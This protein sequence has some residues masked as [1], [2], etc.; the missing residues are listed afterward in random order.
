M[1][2]NIY[3]KT[4]NIKSV[5]FYITLVLAG[6]IGNYFNV[7]LFYG[8]NF[9]FGGIF[10]FIIVLL[11]GT[12]WGTAAALII[13]SYTYFLWNHPYGM[14][15]FTL[16]A[17]FVGLLYKNKKINLV[18]VDFCFWVVAG[19]PLIWFSYKYM[20]DF[21]AGQTIL[22]LLKDIINGIFNSLTASILMFYVPFEQW[23]HKKWT[24]KKR[25]RKPVPMQRYIFSLIISGIIIPTLIIVFSNSY[26]EFNNTMENIKKHTSHY[27]TEISN[28]VKEYNERYLNALTFLSDKI[29]DHETSMVK[30]E[31]ENVLKIFPD[32]LAMY[33]AD[34]KG[35]VIAIDYQNENIENT[36]SELNFSDRDYFK[37]VKSEMKPVISDVFQGRGGLFQPIVIISVPVV[38]DENFEGIICAAV[39]IEHVLNTKVNSDNPEN[40]H[41]SITD[42]SNC[43]VASTIPGLE[44]MYDYDKRKGFVRE[45]KLNGGYIW[46]GT[47]KSN[48][49]VQ[50]WENSSYIYK[51]PVGGK[52][53]WSVIVEKPFAVYQHQLQT[54]YIRN[55]LIIIGVILISFL[56]AFYHSNSFTVP[57]KKLVDISSYLP[58]RLKSLNKIVWPTSWIQE[59]DNLVQNYRKAA[60]KLEDNFKE[61]TEANKLLKK[62]TKHDP[63][64]SLPNMN[65]LRN[66]FSS[67]MI[68]AD[69]RKFKMG[70]LFLD[71]DYFQRVNDILGRPQGDQLLK[72][73]AKRVGNSVKGKGQLYHIGG[74]EFV[75][76]IYN[77][78]DSGD[79]KKIAETIIK[80]LKIPFYFKSQEFYITISIGTAVFPE[81]GETLSILMTN[82]SKAMYAAKDKGKNTVEE[83]TPVMDT[84]ILRTLNLQKDLDKALEREEFLLEY[85]PQVEVRTGQIIGVE[86]L[87][88]WNNPKVGLISPNEFIPLAEETGHIIPIGEW[89]IREACRQNKMWMEK[90]YR[91]VKVAVNLCVCQFQHDDIVEKVENILNQVGLES[92]YLELEITE[93]I[94]INDVYYAIKV[95][96]RLKEMGVNIALDDFGTGFSS[97]NYIRN[98]NI[99]KLKIDQ[100]FI[101]DIYINGKLNKSNAVIIK[102]IID[103]AKN[104]N[105][106]VISEGVETQRQFRFVQKHGCDEVQGFYLSKPLPAGEIE[107]VLEEGG[108]MKIAR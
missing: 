52:V 10:I 12:F 49:V 4:F 103:L 63:L 26:K 96:N 43:I 83:C 40:T 88:R 23:L 100:S 90:G 67:K 92:K 42:S 7:T 60:G 94:I 68:Q 50:Q 108:F 35:S 44:M 93:S 54:Q 76:I 32:I 77:L 24:C 91:P 19:F 85:Q 78:N 99:D 80:E 2:K 38:G 36:H 18:V 15:V 33:V 30:S 62:M 66:D 74:D 1:L 22:V 58:Y 65:S 34:S 73:F 86:A 29:A 87:L 57:L 61:I 3:S 81:D 48:T 16:E 97:L 45:Y 28:Y 5:L 6:I 47:D 98:F 31:I 56:F 64:T 84:A 11:Y 104:L 37:D 39:D 27:A 79:C 25:E 53:P 20:M 21:S 14:I 106:K 59:I 41:I 72:L 107:R 17:L 46:T 105:L 69:N 51:M 75:V 101:K 9:L 82:A 89:V 13:S 55:F 102:T 8:I 70:L 71:I 95:F